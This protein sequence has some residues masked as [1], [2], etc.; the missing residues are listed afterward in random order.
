MSSTEWAAEY[1]HQPLPASSPELRRARYQVDIARRSTT[2]PGSFAVHT[3][4][5]YARLPQATAVACA[6]PDDDDHALITITYYS[7]RDGWQPHLC[8]KRTQGGP[9]TMPGGEA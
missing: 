9:W 2:Q 3:E 1:P 7:E 8:A 4:L 5:R 6:L